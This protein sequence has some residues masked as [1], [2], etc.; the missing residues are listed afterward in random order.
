MPV[1]TR[2]S[3]FLESGIPI[4]NLDLQLLLGGGHTQII[5][6]LDL[7]DTHDSSHHQDD[8]TFLV[9]TSYK[10][11]PSFVTVAGLG[12]DPIYN[13][14]LIS[15]GVNG[16]YSGTLKSLESEEI[17]LFEGSDCGTQMLL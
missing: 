17:N 1:T 13:I 2:I 14:F 6:K 5:Y 10:L 7:Q 12:G 3:T 8:I 9:G 15:F 11:K 4:Y 16:G